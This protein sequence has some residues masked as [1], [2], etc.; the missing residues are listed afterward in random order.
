MEP[1]TEEFSESQRVGSRRSAEAIVPIVLKLIQPR[2]VIDVGC[3]LGTWLSVF[4]QLGIEDVFGIDGDHV[5]RNMLQIA[6]E[7]FLAVDLK[8]PL[9]IDAQFDLAICME[10]AEHLPKECAKTLVESLTKL[11]PVILFFSGNPFPR[12]NRARNRAMARLLGES[13]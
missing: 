3:G 4:G 11:S 10:V 1:Y 13:F 2:N 8:K 6:T 5:D 9:P 7:R 12:G